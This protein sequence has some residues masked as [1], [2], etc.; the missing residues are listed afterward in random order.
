MICPIP[1]H[2]IISFSCL[3]NWI[4]LLS[5][6]TAV[7]RGPSFP[8]FY[9]AL[10]E[11]FSQTQYQAFAICLT[12]LLRRLLF[13][14]TNALLVGSTGCEKQKSVNRSV[15][16]GQCK[17]PPWCLQQGVFSSTGPPVPLLVGGQESLLLESSWEISGS[18][19]CIVCG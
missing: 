19:C 7:G 18:L 5:A 14:S 11:N 8:A 4:K 2:V 13:Y 12:V 6:L 16:V 3:V 10:R 9:T 15:T 1:S 17:D